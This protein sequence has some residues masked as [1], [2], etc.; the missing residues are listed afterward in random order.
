VAEIGLFPLNIV[1]LPTERVP[2]HIFEARY[3]ELIGECLAEKKE[4]GIV[5]ARAEGFANMGTRAT[6]VE[7]LDRFADGRLNIVVEGM[8][9]F[10]VDRLTEGR[11]Y[12][13]AEISDVVD[14]ST[15]ASEVEMQACVEAYRTLSA[16]AGI[17][18][19]APAE[20]AMPEL[21]H[22]APAKSWDL[23][24]L[25]SFPADLKQKLLETTSEPARLAQLTKFMIATAE[26]VRRNRQVRAQAS[27]NG[28]VG[29]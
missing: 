23:A 2:L 29:F 11:S 4:F 1:L 28:H 13:T 21:S 3:K 5:L 27:G 12:T 19:E 25:V 8:S 24:K 15:S 20:S 22:G 18:P 14:D 26:V 10:S 17:V 9:R 7:V 6:I 16:A